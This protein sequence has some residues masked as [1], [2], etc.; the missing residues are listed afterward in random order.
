MCCKAPTESTTALLNNIKIFFALDII[1]AIA[2]VVGNSVFLLTLIRTKS[3][4]RPSNILLGALCVSDL[5]VGYVTRP[6]YVCFLIKILLKQEI[7]V[8]LSVALEISF[9][10]C[11]GLS[12]NLAVHITI[13]RYVAICHPF[14][15]HTFATCKK[16]ILST[17]VSWVLWII[18]IFLGAKWFLTNRLLHDVLTAAIILLAFIVYVVC[19]GKILAVLLKQRLSVINIGEIERQSAEDRQYRKRERAN[20]SM[21]ALVVGFFF[22]SYFP[23]AVFLTY[24]ATRQGSNKK[25]EGSFIASTWIHF[26][27][28]F[29]SCVNPFIYCSKSKEIR[30]ACKKMF[31]SSDL[32]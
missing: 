15:Y 29:N 27:V 5:L 26:L 1:P 4:H 24:T 13:D 17:I 8:E 7:T 19:Y 23:L 18:F 10:L 32:S 3:L 9:L 12:F 28:L 14:F 31:T 2:T 30:N 6:L 11:S 20:T 21:I 16:Y 25:I 22:L